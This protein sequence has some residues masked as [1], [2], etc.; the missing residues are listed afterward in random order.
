[1]GD[2]REKGAFPGDYQLY[3]VHPEYIATPQMMMYAHIA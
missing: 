2:N 1:M 3:S